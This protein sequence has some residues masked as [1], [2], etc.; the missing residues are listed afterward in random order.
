MKLSLALLSI[1]QKPTAGAAGADGSGDVEVEGAEDTINLE[2]CMTLYVHNDRLTANSSDL[3]DT[4]DLMCEKLQ[5]T[6]ATG[7]SSSPI[8]AQFDDDRTSKFI[9]HQVQDL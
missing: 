5:K 8:T 4:N 6:I 1:L 7:A 9:H 2:L 3:L